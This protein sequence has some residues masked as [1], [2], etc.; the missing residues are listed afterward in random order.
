MNR[1][2]NKRSLNSQESIEKAY[3][4]S[5]DMY[6]TEKI[7]VQ[8]IC[9]LANVNRTTFYAHYMDVL[10]L[11]KKIEEKLSR[12]IE[13]IFEEA[14][15]DNTK[16]DLAFFEMFRFIKEHH[17]FYQL[18]LR[19]HNLSILKT[20]LS[21]AD[22]AEEQISHS[23]YHV[24]FFTAGVSEMARIWLNN[25]CRESPEEL[26]QIIYEEYCRV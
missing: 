11:Q 7:T 22:T 5:L 19:Y 17:V 4:E 25:D 16:M 26:A 12:E 18:F 10:D 2:N 14:L 20:I 21:S 9:R 3:I 23:N 15:I 24:S 6:E 13:K 1:K 8:S